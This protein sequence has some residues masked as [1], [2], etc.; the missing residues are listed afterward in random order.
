MKK[1][2]KGFRINAQMFFL[3]YK[4]VDKLVDKQLVLQLVKE[5]IDYLKAQIKHV[6]VSYETGQEKHDS[7]DYEHYHVVLKLNR[8]IEVRD[9]R[10]FDL[11][12]VHGHY[13]SVGCKRNDWRKVVEYV[14]KD[15]NF[16]EDIDRT[17]NVLPLEVKATNESAMLTYLMKEL[18]KRGEKYSK[19]ALFDIVANLN[20]DAKGIYHLKHKMLENGLYN[21]F[22]G[23]IQN[24]TQY[25]IE[26]FHLPA[27][28]KEWDGLR[29]EKSLVLLGK[30]GVGKTELAKCLF[31]NPLFVSHKDR[32]KDLCED[33]DG[34]IFDD[35][36]FSD[37]IAQEKIWLLDLE[38]DRSVG[39]KHGHVVIRAKIPRVFTGNESLKDFLG[40]LSSDEIPM[41]L[42]RRLIHCCV[43]SDMRMID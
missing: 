28:V 20:D 9:A 42:S 29:Y 5:K 41:H 35:F 31:K 2:K 18:E 15:G 33:H 17:P 10:F 23:N 34:I 30:S 27:E 3:T 39:V 32:L 24:L 11:L 7:K 6:V 22:Y 4:K 40:V 14:K 37:L 1:I 12:G 38:N 36:N 8:A 25:N 16:L 13:K 43:L 26:N 21:A 19:N